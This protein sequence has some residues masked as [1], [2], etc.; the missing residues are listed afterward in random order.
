M[1]RLDFIEDSKQAYKFVWQ[2]SRYLGLCAIQVIFI[3]VLC[4][5]MVISQL[6]PDN[7][8]LARGLLMMPANVILAMYLVQ[9]IR[10][11]LYAEPI[12][13]WGT[14]IQA[15]LDYVPC[16]RSEKTVIG[17]AK[18]VQAGIASNLLVMVIFTIFIVV[19]EPYMNSLVNNLDKAEK[20]QNGS[21]LGL[22][23]FTL[24]L[25]G[26]M[27]W[28]L[29]L[30]SLYISFSAGFSPMNFLYRVQG[31]KYSFYFLGT[32][33]LS[34]A[35]P[36]AVWILITILFGIFLPI[37]ALF[38]ITSVILESVINLL[39]VTIFAVTIARRVY[40]TMTDENTR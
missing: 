11:Y 10:F 5:L 23:L 35:L 26:V 34:M 1:T 32:M 27:F 4:K 21:E 20:A 24:F 16:G 7:E 29:R 36:Y 22:I 30:L 3:T 39:I 18:A 13:V 12:F 37:P 38:I 14:Q 9:V 40:I 33:I 19:T 28:S 2:H 15:P 17:R 31:I 8:T 25:M 6:I